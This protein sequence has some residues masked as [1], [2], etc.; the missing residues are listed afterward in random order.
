MGEHEFIR[1]L[2]RELGIPDADVYYES[3]WVFKVDG[4]SAEEALYP[5]MMLR[6]LGWKA[7]ASA[8]SDVYSS[9]SLPVF[10]L[11]SIGVESRE[12]AEELSEGIREAVNFYGGR[13]V[14][15]DTNRCSCGAWVDVFVIGRSLS[16][17]LLGRN[18]G[19]PGDI[20]VQLGSIGLGSAAYHIYKEEMDIRKFP[21]VMEWSL[22]P[23]IPGWIPYTVSH[24]C[25]KAVIDNS[26]GFLYSLRFLAESSG[27]RLAIDDLWFD[28][29]ALS[30]VSG[31]WGKLSSGEDYNL[32][33]L[34][35]N[36]CI[37]GFM[38]YCN[39]YSQGRWGCRVVGVAEDGEPGVVLPGFEEMGG[40]ESF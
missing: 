38:D 29:E 34:V 35:S 31:E 9:G 22:R 14:G 15:G 40:W 36:D 26:D 8:I 28:D 4:Y 23:V 17:R 25:V 18:G 21:H 1:G 19:S 16:G 6:D 13:L 7:V 39:K 30:V 3:G 2:L 24:E 20:V 27:V 37:D 11:V 10:Y 32:F 5:W 33:L 12:R